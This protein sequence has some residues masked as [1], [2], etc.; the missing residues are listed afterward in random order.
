MKDRQNDNAPRFRTE[1][2]AVWKPLRCDAAHAIANHGVELGLVGSEGNASLDFSDELGTES[3]ALRLIPSRR[4]N[5]LCASGTT[6][7]NRK[8]YR[9]MRASADAFTSLHGT[10]SSGFASWSASRRSSSA[11]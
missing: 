4:L 3:R 8:G 1:V 5:E 7:R 9:P 2:D 10:T 11:S 6:K